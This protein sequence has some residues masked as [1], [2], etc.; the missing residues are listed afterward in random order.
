MVVVVLIA[1]IEG[2]VGENKVGKRLFDTA[3]DFYAV[4]AYYLVDEFLHGDIIRC[5]QAKVKPKISRA[6]VL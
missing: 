3:E 6:R 5:K 2:R 4:A 1:D